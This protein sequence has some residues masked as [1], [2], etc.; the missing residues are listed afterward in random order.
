MREAGE[1]GLVRHAAR[2][3][4]RV[5]DRVLVGVVRDEAAA[6]E[7]GPEPR[8]VDRHDRAQ[9]GVAIVERVQ[10]HGADTGKDLEQRHLTS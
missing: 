6:A 5:D 7:R 9:T 1:R 10:L 3:A 2:E 8:V 4:E